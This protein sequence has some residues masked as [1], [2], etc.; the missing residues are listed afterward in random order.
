MLMGT[1]I[2]EIGITINVTDME[3]IRTKTMRAIKEDGKTICSTDTVKK[4][5]QKDQNTKVNM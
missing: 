5:G 2:V 1:S 3:R 4:H